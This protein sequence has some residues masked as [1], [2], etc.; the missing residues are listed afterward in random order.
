MPLVHW[1]IVAVGSSPL[2]WGGWPG[3]HMA[4]ESMETVPF[5]LLWLTLH[6][7]HDPLQAYWRQWSCRRPGATWGT[8]RRK[9]TLAPPRA[10]PQEAGEAHNF[11]SWETHS[12][13]Q[14]H[15]FNSKSSPLAGCQ[16]AYQ[17]SLSLPWLRQIMMFQFI[18]PLLT[19]WFQKLARL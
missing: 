16:V 14:A 2:Q 19:A 9:A 4:L 3:F 18:F 15:Y 17:M 1:C 7:I 13:E 10:N 6:S 11:F 8:G 5:Q 12:W